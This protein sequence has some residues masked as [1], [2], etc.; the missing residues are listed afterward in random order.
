MFS[1]NPM[2]LRTLN[3][4]TIKIPSPL[5][6]ERARVRG[7][8]INNLPFSLSA[9]PIAPVSPAEHFLDALPAPVG[10]PRWYRAR[11]AHFA[12]ENSKIVACEYSVILNKRH[13]PRPVPDV[14]ESRAARRPAPNC[15]VLRRKKNRGS[16]CQLDVA[17]EICRQKNAG[18]AGWPTISSPPR[19]NFSGGYGKLNWRS[20]RDGLVDASIEFK[21]RIDCK[22]GCFSFPLPSTGRGIEGEGWLLF[23]AF[24]F[25]KAFFT[26]PPLTLA[27]S[28]LRGEG[29][30]PRNS[31]FCHNTCS[32]ESFRKRHLSKAFTC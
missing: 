13:A 10:Q 22:A 5:N 26:L 12:I 17:A 8:Q 4:R 19:W 3:R 30:A 6:G 24:K 11:S 23:E 27:L 29:N 14:Q 16:V 18:R 7:G 31:S 21:T 20:R 15:S 32:G 2:D 1:H 25:C 28:P 9:L